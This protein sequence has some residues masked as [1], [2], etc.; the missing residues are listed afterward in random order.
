MNIRNWPLDRIL[1]LPDCCFGRRYIVSCVAEAEAAA[2]AWDISEVAFPEVGVIWDVQ[3]WPDSVGSQSLGIRLALGD[4][5]P[6]TLAQMTGLE[7]LIQGLGEWSLGRR[8]IP[9]GSDSIVIL[10]RIKLPVRFGGRRLV[11][12][13]G[14]ALEA[15]SK[16]A[17]A[18][19]VSSIPTEVSDW[20]CS[21]RV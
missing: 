21:G 10:S 7:Q 5:L 4:Q 18:V 16:V 14:A 12:E 19:T 11:L 8:R 3:W 15:A 6:T 9:V 17:V 2:T 13:N 20:L 1:Q